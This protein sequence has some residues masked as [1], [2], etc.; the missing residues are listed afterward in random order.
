MNN[1]DEVFEDPH[2]I[3][4]NRPTSGLVPAIKEWG[5]PTEP[6]TFILDSQ[7]LVQV[8]FEQ[9]TPADEIEAKLLE[10]LSRG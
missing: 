7:G 6:W 8:K 1:V 5:L 4:G 10:V 9:F 3:E 2:L